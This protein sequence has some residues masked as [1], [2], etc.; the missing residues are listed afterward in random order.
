MTYQNDLKE[1]AKELIEAN[2]SISSDK[3]IKVFEYLIKISNYEHPLPIDITKCNTTSSDESDA[4]FYALSAILSNDLFNYNTL[5]AATDGMMLASEHSPEVRKNSLCIAATGGEKKIRT[6]YVTIPV[7]IIC[8][9]YVPTIVQGN[10]AVTGCN[11]GGWAESDMMEYFH[12]P[13]FLTRETG[14]KIL[15]QTNFLY[16][17]AKSYHPILRRFARQRGAIGFR[18]IFKI[19]T[20]LSDPFRCEYQY[21]CVWNLELAK[22]SA[23]VFSEL[24]HVRKAIVTSGELFGIDEFPITGGH[25]F[26]AE[27]HNIAE[28]DIHTGVE[29]GDIN[30]LG[31]ERDLGE[32]SWSI[33][34][35]LNPDNS[36]SK[37]LE[38]RNLVKVNAGLALSTAL[39]NN[40]D[41]LMAMIETD[42]NNKK[43]LRKL[44]EIKANAL[45]VG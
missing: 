25:F 37:I 29:I 20:G 28:K 41:E 3:I 44:E 10:R 38:K 5:K 26:I 15:F 24:N 7:G 32:E 33:E 2:K 40:F 14:D 42:I 30:D 17:H 9:L 13:L 11:C 39:N 8:S 18:D 45:D 27:K 43:A 1:L 6:L 34:A 31:H 21:L 22:I 12:Y 23:K 19:A 35:I 16:A 4:L 36:A